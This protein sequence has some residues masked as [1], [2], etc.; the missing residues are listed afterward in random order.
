MVRMSVLADSLK[1][2]INAEKAGKRQVLLRPTSKVLVKFLRVMQKHGYIAEFSIVD[3]KR[4]G[5]IIV[6]LN[7]RLNKCGVISPRYDLKLKN[8]EKFIYNILPSRQFGYVI[9]TTTFGIMDH[10]EAKRKHIGGK[11]LGYFY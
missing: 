9:L 5:K 10:E 6:E 1:S 7:G 4:N 3:D 2:I 8:F 11:V